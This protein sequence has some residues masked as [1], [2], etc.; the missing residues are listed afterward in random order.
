M[1]HG[2]R[3]CGDSVEIHSFPTRAVPGLNSTAMFFL[4]RPASNKPLLQQ[5][6]G[7]TFQNGH[8]PGP[9]PE[10]TCERS[11]FI[12]VGA[13]CEFGWPGL[14]RLVRKWRIHGPEDTDPVDR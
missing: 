5:L 12:G 3:R 1:Q 9:F 14:M 10:Q 6:A 2:R 7:D 4:R 8:P 11:Q 13:C